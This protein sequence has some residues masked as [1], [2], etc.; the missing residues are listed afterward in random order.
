MKGFKVK[1]LEQ[2]KWERFKY[3]YEMAKLEK[4]YNDGSIHLKKLER[5]LRYYKNKLK[6]L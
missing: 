6:N 3:E 2:I 4:E 1:T 5:R